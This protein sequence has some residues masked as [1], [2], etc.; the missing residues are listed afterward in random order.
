M[1]TKQLVMLQIPKES[2]Q[3]IFGKL[4]A[5]LN[6]KLQKTIEAR[7]SQIEQKMTQWESNY[8]GIPRTQGTRTTPFV[9]AA[10]FVP[11][12]IRMHV[13]I[14][15]ARIQGLLW[16]VKPF[17]K[18]T[19]YSSSIK[20]EWLDQLSEWMDYKWYNEI[21]AFDSVDASLH[22]VAKL[23][24]S[25]LKPTW[26]ERQK[27]FATQ[28][29][30]I[31]NKTFKK[32][33][34]FPI[35]FNDFLP[36]PI[37]A[38]TLKQ[39]T[40]KFHRLRYT[41]EEV[42]F[43]IN[44]SEWDQS[45]GQLVLRSPITSEGTAAEKSSNFSGIF[46]SP[47]VTRPYQVVEAWLDYELSPGQMHSIVVVFNPQMNSHQSIIRAYY[48]PIGLDQEAFVD[49][50]LFIKNNSF[51]PDSIP[52]MLED[53]QEE[54]AQIHNT[55]RDASTVTNIPSWAKKRYSDVG[56]PKDEW[57]PGKVWELENMDDLKMLTMTGNYNHMIEEERYVDQDAEKLVGN[58]PPSQ[59][60]ASGSM[61]K[62][63]VYNTQGTLALMAAGNDR[64]DNIMRRM[65]LPFHRIGR[66][67][68]N[69][70]RDFGD[71]GQAQAGEPDLQAAFNLK[72][73]QGYEGTFFGLGCSDAGSNRETERTSLLLMGN[74]MASYYSQIMGL[75]PQV[76]QAQGPVQELMFEVLD[77]ARDLASRL[78][79]AFNI[80]DRKK[81]VPDL[82]AMLS[83]KS[84][85]DGPT[86]PNR[87]GVPGPEAPVQ[88]SDLQD[89]SSTVAAIAGAN[90]TGAGSGGGANGRPPV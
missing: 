53:S 2:Q 69:N 23:G 44:T 55:R 6:Q 22:D 18:P 37:T 33:E 27:F 4:S 21:E 1:P 17:W 5:F 87:A 47:D 45:A 60:F 26:V 3:N 36:Y 32:T 9:G 85:N 38:R 65:R 74:T 80:P 75:L 7:S 15:H 82:R 89:L 52:Q 24:V 62:R 16:G 67:I 34:I 88:Q 40:I 57:F 41:Q 66:A 58:P 51:Y 71:E 30:R 49:F 72:P 77:G 46:L 73:P 8:Q 35:G 61:G 12:L 20:H 25:I 84:P 81:L 13:D 64:L 59:G 50:R 29:G 63:G 70:Y 76:V 42:Q 83:G 54:K 86:P 48:H 56:S 11:G 14:M 19:W 31:E 39:C 68:Y 79:T 28:P 90:R 78:L 10:N 43:K